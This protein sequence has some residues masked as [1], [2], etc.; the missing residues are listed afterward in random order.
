MSSTKQ[1]AES[2]VPGSGQSATEHARE[3]VQDSAQQVQEQVGQKAQEMR[4]HAGER[5][6][7]QLDTRSS[8]AG[9][10][11]TATA[12][13]IRR[14]GQQLRSEGNDGTAKYADQV[15]DRAERLGNYL[16]HGDADRLLRDVEN[17]ARRQPLLTAL[18]GAAFGF[19]ASRFLKASSANRYR[20]SYSQDRA[21]RLALPSPPEGA[22]R[23]SPAGGS[24]AKVDVASTGAGRSGVRGQP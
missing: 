13:A 21:P 9:E 3:I 14:V 11:V 7:E 5:V 15:A 16:A 10:Q 24:S 23:T 12:G 22:A 19:L 1:T 20:Q 17:F 18:G 8:Q 6:R 2:G 4:M